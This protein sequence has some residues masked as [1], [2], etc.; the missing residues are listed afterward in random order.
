M[1]RCHLFNCWVVDGFPKFRWAT[2]ICI[3]WNPFLKAHNLE[4]LWQ[5]PWNIYCVTCS[6]KNLNLQMTTIRHENW[7][8]LTVDFQSV[9]RRLNGLFWFFV[10][11][12][13]LRHV[14]LYE[15]YQFV[16]S[17]IKWNYN[18]I[19]FVSRHHGCELLLSMKLKKETLRWPC[20]QDKIT[21]WRVHVLGFV[22]GKQ[23]EMPAR[24]VVPSSCHQARGTP[25]GRF[26]RK[27]RGF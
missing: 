24:V 20:G 8:M 26:F 2:L 5:R 21:S 15:M 17:Y 18:I 19:I 7:F 22:Y 16:A 25:S 6:F 9:M 14:Q 11:K 13:Y 27:W 4:I 12:N 23:E 10:L 1:V 3:K